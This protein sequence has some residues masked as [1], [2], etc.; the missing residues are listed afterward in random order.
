MKKLSKKKETESN[1]V[2][3][4]RRVSFIIPPSLLKNVIYVF[5]LDCFIR[6]A[7]YS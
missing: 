4:E 5:Y 1:G 3:K 7:T 2:K 6:F